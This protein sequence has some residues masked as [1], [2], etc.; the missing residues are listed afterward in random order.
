MYVLFW[1]VRMNIDR[2]TAGHSFAEGHMADSNSE[3]C[4]H[5]RCPGKEG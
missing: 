1:P 2:S 5:V 4:S 3:F